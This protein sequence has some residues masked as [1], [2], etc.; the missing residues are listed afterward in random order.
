MHRVFKNVPLT[1]KRMDIS[2]S[3]V[4]SWQAGTIPNLKMMFD[5]NRVFGIDLSYVY[6]YNFFNILRESKVT[7]FGLEEM[8][9][10]IKNFPFTVEDKAFLAEKCKQRFNEKARCE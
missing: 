1:A 4:Y 7:K 3:T 5:I 8:L 9:E 10:R 6:A 2:E